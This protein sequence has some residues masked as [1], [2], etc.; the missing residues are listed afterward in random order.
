M[1]TPSSTKMRN[2]TLRLGQRQRACQWDQSGVV[3]PNPDAP[4]GRQL[5]L[6]A[7]VEAL[8]ESRTCHQ[9]AARGGY[10]ELGFEQRAGHDRGAPHPPSIPG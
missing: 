1:R 6:C 8:A 3:L 7:S 2:V 9:A 10:V 4:N 5:R